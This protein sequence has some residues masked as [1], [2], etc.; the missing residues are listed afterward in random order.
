MPLYTEPETLRVTRL[1][2]KYIFYQL[3]ST[4]TWF[5]YN[6]KCLVKTKKATA[7]SCR[8]R[9]NCCRSFTCNLTGVASV[10]VD[11]IRGCTDR[12][13]GVWEKWSEWRVN[14][15]NT[16]HRYVFLLH[17]PPCKPTPKT[18]NTSGMTSRLPV[19]YGTRLYIK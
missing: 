19:T 9:H 17:F 11:Y 18:T 2:V 4:V 14:W 16:A 15:Q 7:T 12:C 5:E 3:A 13:Q 6:R 1:E 10:T 8:K